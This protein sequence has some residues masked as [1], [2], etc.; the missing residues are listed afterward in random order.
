MFATATHL[1]QGHGGG[2]GTHSEVK[3]IGTQTKTSKLDMSTFFIAEHDAS[4][5]TRSSAYRHNLLMGN[6]ISAIVA[7]SDTTRGSLIGIWYYICK[8]PQHVN[9]IR[10]ELHNIDIN[11]MQKLAALP[12]LNAV[13]KET[14][15]LAPPAMTGSPR[16]TGPGGLMVGDVWI[17]GGVKVTAPKYVMHRCESSELVLF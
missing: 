3:L 9:K 16:M 11:N 13:I 17:P 5:A 8:F 10:S 2:I 1:R 4:A 7:G 6:S 14:L 15:R 12:H